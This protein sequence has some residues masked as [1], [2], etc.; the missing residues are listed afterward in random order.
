MNQFC[1]S[2]N[3]MQLIV[4]HLSIHIEHRFYVV[5]YTVP[6]NADFFDYSYF[7]LKCLNIGLSPRTFYVQCKL[8]LCK[9]RVR[10]CSAVFTDDIV[11][12]PA[13]IV[14]HDTVNGNKKEPLYFTA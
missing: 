10:I 12:N 1:N 7:R 2:V 14:D 6:I 9:R 13:E 5:I 11:D 3:V 8:I 4:F